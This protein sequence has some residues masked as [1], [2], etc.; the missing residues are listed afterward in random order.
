MIPVLT[1]FDDAIPGQFCAKLREEV[2]YDGFETVM[3]S[4]GEGLAPVPY[5]TVNVKK[6]MSEMFQLIG[7]ALGQTV[8]PVVHAFRLGAENS[9]IANRVHADH[10]RASLACVLYLNREN[11]CKGGTAFWKH[12]KHG[13]HFM[14]NKEQL[15]SVGYT[16]EQLSE[17]ANDKDAWELVTLAGMKHNRL[18][19]YPTQAL[20]SRYPHEGFGDQSKPDTCRLIWAGFFNL[21]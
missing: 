14:P 21:K 18:I 9:P 17:D 13:W 12:K 2:L 1:L 4:D 7:I 20:H 19:V 15:E 10:T 11:Q 16:I 3:Y 6:D 8:I 5:H